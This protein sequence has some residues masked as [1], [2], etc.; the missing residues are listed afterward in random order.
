MAKCDNRK[1]NLVV[2]VAF[3]GAPPPPPIGYDHTSRHMDSLA[4]GLSSPTPHIIIII[5]IMITSSS[6]NI[7]ALTNRNTHQTFCMRTLSSM[8]L[9]RPKLT[10]MEVRIIIIPS[11]IVHNGSVWFIALTNYYRRGVMQCHLANVYLLL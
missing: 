7:F 6:S 10:I 8:F 11:L 1:P 4:N 9:R 2:I 5:I 3:E